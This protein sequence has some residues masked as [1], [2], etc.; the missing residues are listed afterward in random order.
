MKKDRTNKVKKIKA[1][2]KLRTAAKKKVVKGR[3]RKKPGMGGS[4]KF[5][6]VVVR[7]KAEFK[8]F[9]NHVSKLQF[10]ISWPCKNYLIICNFF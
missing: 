2:L 10:S 4:G 6:R 3:A 9:R 1:G 8:I 5:Y 7:P